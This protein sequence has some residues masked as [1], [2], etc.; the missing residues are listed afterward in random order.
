MYISDTNAELINA[1]LTIRDDVES[2]I[3]IL[4]EMQNDFLVKSPDDKQAYYLSK[5][6]L[7]NDMILNP[8]KSSPDALFKQNLL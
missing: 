8:D 1:Y 2:L 6:S 5:R 3:A 7:F 4:L